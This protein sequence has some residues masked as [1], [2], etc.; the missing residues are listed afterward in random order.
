[1][2]SRKTVLKTLEFDSPKRIPRHLWSLPWTKNNYPNELNEII[3]R[4]PSDIDVAPGFGEK[5]PLIR[6]D[7]YKVG[8]YIDDWGCIFSNMHDGIIG[9]VKEALIKDD[10][11]ENW[12]DIRFPKEYLTID[13]ERINTFCKNSDKF[14]IAGNV[15]RP[16]ERLQFLR[17]TEN[18][19]VD[20]ITRPPNMIKFLEKLHNFYLDVYENWAK[21]DIDAIMI[22]D[23]WGSQNSLLI[24]L[25]TWR[26]VFKPMYREYADIGK[27]Y[28]KKVFMHSDGFILPIY[29][30]L[31]EIGIDAINSQIFCMGIDKLSKYSGKITFWGEI[32][33][34]NLL[35]NASEKDIENAVNEIMNNLYSNGG[36]IGQL[37]FG[38]GAKPENVKK[39]FET[40][41]RYPTS[42]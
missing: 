41:D 22:M 24:N 32:D 27:K 20:L 3:K 15:L 31:I 8:T 14:L 17:G 36:V 42:D 19:F 38:P 21:T 9:E 29:D 6:G 5:S 13:K 30:D 1:M 39:A 25:E 4:Y 35:P 11:W 2:D 12:N 37:E 18:L 23:D 10:E 33:R 7:A 26:Q 34:Q 40:W 16:F 28:N